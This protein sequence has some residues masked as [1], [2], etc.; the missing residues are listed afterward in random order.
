VGVCWLMD[1]APDSLG[2]SPPG[3]QSFAWH[4]PSPGLTGMGS[5]GMPRLYRRARTSARRLLFIVH[6]EYPFDE[7]RVRRQ[8]E[9]AERVGWAVDVLALAS[10]GCPSTE[11]VEGVR[12]F[13]T[14]VR[15]LRHMSARGLVFEYGQFWRAAAAFCRHA[16]P[17]RTIVVANPPDFLVFATLSQR[18]RGAVILLDIHD[19]MTDLFAVRVQKSIDSPEMRVLAALERCSMRYA[20]RLMTVHEPYK[21]EVERRAGSHR[22]VAVVMNSADPRLFAHR[23]RPPGATP[24][25]GYHGSVFERYGVFDLLRAFARLGDRMPT[26]ELWVLGGGDAADALQAEA[27]RIGVADRCRFSDGVMSVEEIAEL[28]P[29]FHV[30]VIPNHP[31]ALN[32]YALSTKLFEYVAVGVPVVCVRLETLAAHFSEEELLYY[33]PASVDDLADKLL[34]SLAQPKQSLE[35]AR[36][37]AQRYEASYGWSQSRDVLLQQID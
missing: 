7:T 13:R 16:E 34:A 33:A 20:D 21:L 30:G 22:E 18:C 9:A 6:S 31:N 14:K 17:Y 8:A 37:A 10:E 15:R 32:R 1:A 27:R 12:V 25:V 11:I 4:A 29:D 3:G 28:L 19:L 23:D 35:R 24:V 36:R 26:A 5:Q 2:P